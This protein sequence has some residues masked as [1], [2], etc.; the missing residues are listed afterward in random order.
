MCFLQGIKLYIKH[1]APKTLTFQVAHSHLCHTV[2][3]GHTDL[4]EVGHGC[5]K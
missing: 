1:V 2:E 3:V 4:L 5:L